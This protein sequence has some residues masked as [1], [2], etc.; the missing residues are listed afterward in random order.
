MRSRLERRAKN[1]EMRKRNGVVVQL[2]KNVAHLEQQDKF[3]GGDKEGQEDEEKMFS[4]RP[5]GTYKL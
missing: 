3:L 4:E 2:Q 1:K 5:N